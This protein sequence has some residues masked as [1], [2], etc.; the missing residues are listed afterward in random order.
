MKRIYFSIFAA[1]FFCSLALAQNSFLA[2]PKGW[3]LLDHDSA[4]Y[5][6]I[7]LHKAY[8]F[9]K[10]K[11]LQPRKVVVAVIDSGIDTAHEDLKP[12][13]WINK[14]EI[15]GNGIDDDNNGYID[16]VH[17]WNFVGGRDGRNVKENSLEAVRLY[18]KFKSK[19]GAVPPDENAVKPEQKEEIELYKKVQQKL[20]GDINPAEIFLYKRLLTTFKKGDSTIQRELDKEEYT[21]ADLETYY[22]TNKDAKKSKK[23][24]QELCVA[25][26]GDEISN[27]ELVEHLQKDISKADALDVAP[28]DFRKEIVQ[29]DEN[30]INDRYYGNN[31]LMAATA[32]HGTHC[33]GI[34]AAV[35]NNDIGIQGIA[36]N[37]SIMMVRAVPDGDEHDK[38]VANSIRYAVDNG[39]QII[40]MSFGKGFSPQKHWVD[41]A[42]RYAES[43]GV[44]LIHAAGNDS[45]N[46]D[47]TENYPC[48]KY[49]DGKI[50]T[51]WIEVGA[52]GDLANGGYTAY[53]SNYG[54]KTV[55]V[56][57]PGVNI[58]ST[59]PGGNKYG[60]ESGTSMA[61]PVVAGTAALIWGYYPS[62]SASQVKYVI[63]KSVQA[64][65]M[66]VKIPGT[67]KTAPMSDLCKTGGIIN[68][69][70]AVKLASTLHAEHKQPY[71]NKTQKE[72]LPKPKLKK[73]VKG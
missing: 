60:N 21:C 10:T 67:D 66:E 23:L 12:I 50:A 29:D 11:K 2:P 68:A 46:T 45:K 38:D 36:D 3:H 4:G 13:L 9:I 5:F 71:K 52:S 25:N 22:P 41:D 62:L 7:S 14:K 51:N 28:R 1:F 19:Y 64:P 31:D 57:A 27:K 16:D 61:C 20:L 48:A 58:Y 49:L 37:V 47:S 54:K 32:T 24:L 70:R 63:E 73:A 33:S 8:D 43:K 17:G 40:S 69:Y 42:V 55:D 35:R 30:D 39:A 44:L 6:G 15:P 59:L 18:H 26:K 56:F 34:I 72:V 53:F 65:D